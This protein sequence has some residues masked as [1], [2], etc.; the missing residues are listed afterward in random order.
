ML[1][2]EP[3]SGLDPTTLDHDLSRNQES[4]G[5]PNERL[6]HP[7]SSLLDSIPDCYVPISLWNMAPLLLSALMSPLLV[8]IPTSR[9]PFAR[10]CSL[11]LQPDLYCTSLPRPKLQPATLP[12]TQPLQTSVDRAMPQSGQLET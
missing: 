8:G 3:N 4:D 10:A 1:S 11:P 5:Q 7:F 6:R 2:A 12:L 9:T